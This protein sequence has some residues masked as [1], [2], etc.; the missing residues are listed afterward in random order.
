[1]SP[2]LPERPRQ[3]LARITQPLKLLRARL[4]E[5]LVRERQTLSIGPRGIALGDGPL[6]AAAWPPRQAAPLEALLDLLTVALVPLRAGVR[7]QVV[8]ADAWCRTHFPDFPPGLRRDEHAAFLQQSFVET[9]GDAAAEWVIC[10]ARELPGDP[11]FAVAID[12][13]LHQAINT[14][15]AT[16]RLRLT[17][18][19]PRWAALAD[20]S[21][22]RLLGP[23]GALLSAADGCA[24]LAVW[25]DGAWRWHRVQAVGEVGE[26]GWSGLL[27][28]GL[29]ALPQG[30]VARVHCVGTRP[31]VALRLPEGWSL[32]LLDEV[33]A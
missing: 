10:A 22:S 18:L 24:S 32:A 3:P 31:P 7:L 15:V 29:P 16:Q 14:V 9:F 21:R 12:A 1:V 23:R 8:V 6:L 19:R 11:P 4:R 28:A 33:A 17:S 30:E 26:A 13:V 27:H 20:A 5:A 2:S 25:H